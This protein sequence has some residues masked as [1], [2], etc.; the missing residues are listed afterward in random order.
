[1][2]LHPQFLPIRMGRSHG[3]GR[4]R[5]N[6]S[7]YS[8]Y[9]TDVSVHSVSEMDAGVQIKTD[10]GVHSVSKMD[11]GIQIKTDAGVH[12][13]KILDAGVHLNLE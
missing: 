3:A 11:A 6:A 13:L 7:T 5:K 1:M 8:D 9:K 4:H 12:F 2:S 10:A